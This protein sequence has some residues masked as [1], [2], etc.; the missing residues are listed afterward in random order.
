MIF[1]GKI[2]PTLDDAR[3][4]ALQKLADGSAF[5]KFRDCVTAQGGDPR[6]LDKFELL[7][8]A[9]GCGKLLPT[10]RLRDAD[11]RRRHWS[12]LGLMVPV[13]EKDDKI[14][15]AVGVILGSQSRR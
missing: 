13:G 8:N 11:R 9:T 6:A 10:R 14:D 4:L 7:P 2:V 15:P 12:S 5:R 1:L 3:E